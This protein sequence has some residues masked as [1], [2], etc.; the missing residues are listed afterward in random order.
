M[1][2]HAAGQAQG[3]SIRRAPAF[4]VY[5]WFSHGIL[6]NPVTLTFVAGVCWDLA[7]SCTTAAA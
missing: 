7:S 2:P 3:H 4:G 5:H 1:T 6:G